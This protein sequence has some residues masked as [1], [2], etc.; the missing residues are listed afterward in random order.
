MITRSLSQR[1]FV[2]VIG[3]VIK[4]TKQMQIAM[5]DLEK[6]ALHGKANRSGQFAYIPCSAFRFVVTVAVFLLAAKL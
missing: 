4:K 5:L 3:L 1:V 6:G 2:A